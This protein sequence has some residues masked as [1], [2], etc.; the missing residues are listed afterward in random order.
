[1]KPNASSKGFTLIEL[2]VVIGIIGVLITNIYIKI[3]SNSQNAINEKAFKSQFRSIIQL[4]KHE[5]VI[6]NKQIAPERSGRSSSY[7]NFKHVTKHS[8]AE[9]RNLSS[10][11]CTLFMCLGVFSFLFAPR[12]LC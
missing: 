3:D 12:S 5:A 9:D 8:A 2:L 11:G 7:L 6:N 1:M 4:V 10:P